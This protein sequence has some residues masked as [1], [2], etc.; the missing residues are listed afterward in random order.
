MTQ[1]R[2]ITSNSIIAKNDFVEGKSFRH[3]YNS[4]GAKYNY[5]NTLMMDGIYYVILREGID[6]YVIQGSFFCARYGK[7]NVHYK[8]YKRINDAIKYANRL[9]EAALK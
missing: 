7:E 1:R 4:G 8:A 5:C 9:A 2:S 6:R 3:T